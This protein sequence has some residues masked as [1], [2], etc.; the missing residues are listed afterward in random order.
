MKTLIYY[1]MLRLTAQISRFYELST[2]G[3]SMSLHKK[4]GNLLPH[5]ISSMGYIALESL[6]KMGE[7]MYLVEK[8][9]AK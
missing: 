9:D 1:E 5:S 3:L 7:L 4:Y 8:V 6:K 2:P